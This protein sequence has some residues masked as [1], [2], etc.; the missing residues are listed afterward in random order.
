M[1][2]RFVRLSLRRLDQVRRQVIRR[3]RPSLELLL[4]LQ[5]LALLLQRNR[6]WHLQHRGLRLPERL[7]LVLRGIQQLPRRAPSRLVPVLKGPAPRQLDS[8]ILPAPLA[9]R[10]RARAGPARRRACV[11]QPQEGRLDL[12]ALLV[13]EVHH[14][15]SRSGRAA[16]EG[17][18]ARVLSAGK[19][20]VP[21]FQRLSQASRSTLV[22]LPHRAAVH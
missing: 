20:P 19:D 10:A 8:D 1:S 13:P 22:S 11:R 21:A 12:V 15:D 7:R 17:V 3:L 5:R 2:C 18:P 9:L 6:G 4:Q 16:P 14:P